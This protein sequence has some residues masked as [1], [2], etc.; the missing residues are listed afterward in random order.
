MVEAETTLALAFS[1]GIEVASLSVALPKGEAF[2]GDSPSFASIPHSTPQ[3]CKYAHLS[4]TRCPDGFPRFLIPWSE[5][6]GFSAPNG[7]FCHCQVDF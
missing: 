3:V 7:S 4:E 6:F 1:P 5:V 2:H